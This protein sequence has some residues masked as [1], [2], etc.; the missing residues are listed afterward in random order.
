QMIDGINAIVAFSPTCDPPNW[1]DT[2]AGTYTPG[3]SGSS[4]KFSLSTAATT[5]CLS[6]LY[7]VNGFA[8]PN[9]IGKDISSFNVTL[10][11][12]AGVKLDS[13]CVDVSDT[14]YSRIDTC[15][16]TTYDAHLTDN[17]YCANNAWAGA[18]KACDEK[19]MR[20][21]DRTELSN[22]YINYK[23]GGNTVSMEAVYYWT[24]VEADASN[25]YHQYF[26]SSINMQSSYIKIFTGHARCVK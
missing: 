25:A 17:S 10:P 11:T 9:K 12:C 4:K 1:T 3:A 19:G 5:S 24:S 16:D 8:S 23:T 15:S 14:S 7:D 13:L 21:P 18:K 20:L 22:L 2:S 26:G 6:I